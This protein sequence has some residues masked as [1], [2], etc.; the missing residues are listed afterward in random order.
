MNHKKPKNY[1]VARGFSFGETLLAAFV[2]SVGL[3]SIVKLF[4][5]SLSQ[6]LFLRDATIA[7][8]LA[9]EG[10]ELVRNVRDNNFI[11]GG[12]GF[13]SFNGSNKHC[14]IAVD[15]PILNCFSSQSGTS[16]YNLV[17]QGGQYVSTTTAS[18]FQ[19]YIYVDY[20][21]SSLQATVKSFVVWSGA[22]LPPTTGSTTGCTIQNKCVYTEVLLTN[23]KS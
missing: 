2:L 20:S 22:A 17:Y 14:Y 21:S 7:S 5:V 10:A 1:K 19:R 18:R 15:S 11:A 8:E 23:W 16:R 4:Q 12:T 3:L 13:A 6:S 9:Q